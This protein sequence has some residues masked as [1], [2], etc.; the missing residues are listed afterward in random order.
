MHAMLRHLTCARRV[1][2]AFEIA[3]STTCGTFNDLA[4]LKS[5]N[6][7]HSSTFTITALASVLLT[8]SIV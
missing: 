2:G 8:S 1:E 6:I 7:V 3:M 4:N 5:L